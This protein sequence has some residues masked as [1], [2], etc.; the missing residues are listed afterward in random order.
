MY[1]YMYVKSHGIVYL[2]YGFFSS[3]I[4]SQ[5][6]FILR[7]VVVHSLPFCRFSLYE[8]GTIYLPILR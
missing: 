7:V 6:L 5:D 8:H 4:P 2:M 1:L 3:K